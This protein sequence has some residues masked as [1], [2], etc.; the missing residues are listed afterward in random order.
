[1]EKIQFVSLRPDRLR[2][3]YVSAENLDASIQH[4]FRRLL[5]RKAAVSTT[6]EVCRASHIAADPQS[7]KY[8]LVI[9]QH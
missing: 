7:G 3:I 8:R 9:I 2:I 5:D 6:F 1:L 4:E